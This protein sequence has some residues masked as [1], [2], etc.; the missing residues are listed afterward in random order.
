M[1]RYS[2]H[3]S[4]EGVEKRVQ[5]H[6]GDLGIAVPLAEVIQAAEREFAGVPFQDLAIGGFGYHNSLDGR[7][8]DFSEVTLEH[9]SRS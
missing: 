1:E 9:K 4:G 6:L 3:V 2:V 5:W 8:G 7:G